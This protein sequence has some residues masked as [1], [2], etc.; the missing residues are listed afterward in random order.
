GGESLTPRLR[1]VLARIVEHV[2][3]G[4]GLA[5]KRIRAATGATDGALR[6]LAAAGAL[7]AVQVEAEP[8]AK[9]RA[10]RFAPPPRTESLALREAQARALGRIAE[11]L[12]AG[13]FGSFLLQGVTGS[14]KT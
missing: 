7:E 4:R 13:E 14:G 10:P 9:S 12:D 1:E 5:A 11:R 2:R 8:P 3:D 6:K